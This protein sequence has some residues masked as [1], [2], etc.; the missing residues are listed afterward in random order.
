MLEC[1]ICGKKVS[2][3]LSHLKKTHKMSKADY[4]KLFGS[5]DF[6]SPELRL[7]LTAAAYRHIK[8]VELNLSKSSKRR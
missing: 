8:Q 6:V 3:L 4:E 2:R 5:T 7:S 1:K